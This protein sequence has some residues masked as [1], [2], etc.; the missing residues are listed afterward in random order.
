M[1]HLFRISLATLIFIVAA[2]ATAH[3]QDATALNTRLENAAQDAA[4]D[5][6]T[7]KPWHLTLDVQLFDAKGK[8]S[9]RGTIEEWWAG[10]DL[11]KIS[12]AFPSY[13]ATQ[14]LNKEGYF[15]TKDTSY[16]PSILVDMVEQTAH[17]MPIGDPNQ[18]DTTIPEL[19]KQKFGKVELECIMLKQ[20]L[21][22]VPFPPLGLF[23]TYCL[24][25]G[26]D[27]L[28]VSTEL[29][30]ITVIRNRTGRF[31]GQSVPVDLAAESGGVLAATAHLNSLNSFTPT[32]ADFAPGPDL[33]SHSSKLARIGG[34]IMNG[35]KLTDVPPIYP[36]KAKLQHITGT[37]VLK[38]IIGRDG[39]VR[40]LH[41]ASTPDADLAMAAIASV[42]RWTYK[43]YLLNGVPTEV[44]TT[45]TVNFAISP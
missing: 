44:D 29:G 31:Q 28:R 3:A 32:D 24:D 13:T 17:P 38:A 16:A 43:P 34:G 25:P 40:A 7:L 10:R 5:L 30:S 41:I 18:P 15:Q 19:R 21:K 11:N 23:P 8:P 33:E 12:F 4:L 36:E 35:Q 1:F 2:S 22:N 9:E 37:V 42:R 39:R 27:S 20:P 6:P 45:V 26:K 14:L